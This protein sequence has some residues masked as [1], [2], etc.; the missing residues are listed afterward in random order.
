MM[1]KY[2]I[3]FTATIIFLAVFITWG[4]RSGRAHTSAGT[5]QKALSLAEGN[6]TFALSMMTALGSKEENMAFSP[7]SISSAM[8]MVYAGAA[9]KTADEMKSI[10]FYPPYSPELFN[11]FNKLNKAIVDDPDGQVKISLANSVWIQDKYPIEPVYGRI[12]QEDFLAP[13]AKVDFINPQAREKARSTINDWTAKNTGERIKEILPPGILNE[14]TRLVLTNAIYFKGKWAHP[15]NRNITAPGPFYKETG[16]NIKTPFMHGNFK[17]QI[18]AN[19]TLSMLSLPYESENYSL[20]ILLPSS[21]WSVSRLSSILSEANIMRWLSAQALLQAEIT[22]P[23][24]K[25]EKSIDAKALLMEMGLKEPFALSAD[26]SGITGNK[27]LRVDD[28]LHKAFIEV[29]E[30]GTEAAAATAAVIGLKAAF[31]GEPVHFTVDR[32]FIF[33]LLEKSTGTIL[34]AGK[35][36]DPS[37]N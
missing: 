21:A 11:E 36:Y 31:P 25:V 1:K 10:F 3:L 8:G 28:V 9:G 32:P 18:Y 5:E 13:S 30:D 17:A 6:R 15:F 19:D 34:F 29:N 12:L 7:Y 27:D 22:I 37:Q 24:F 35:I 16:E 33:L 26:L 14:N 4:C 20:E 2:G 23:S